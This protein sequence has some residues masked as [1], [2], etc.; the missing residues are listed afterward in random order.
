MAGQFG[1][2]LQLIERVTE[3]SQ[4]EFAEMGPEDRAAIENVR[5]SMDLPRIPVASIKRIYRGR[6]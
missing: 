3:I 1:A 6:F 5:K 4:A 2:S